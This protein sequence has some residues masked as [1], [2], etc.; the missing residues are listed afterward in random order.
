VEADATASRLRPEV[1][2]SAGCSLVLCSSKWCNMEVTGHAVDQFDV[3]SASTVFWDT[4]PVLLQRSDR[5][6]V[7]DVLSVRLLVGHTRH[8]LNMKVLRMHIFSDSDLLVLH[9]LEVSE[10]DF[11]TLKAE[12]GILVDFAN[13]SGK[14]IDLLRRCIASKDEDVPRFRA[15]LVMSAGESVFKMVE[16]NDFKQLPH[17]SL[18]FRPGTDMAIKSFL[19]FRLTEVQQE[20]STLQKDLAANRGELDTARR[21]LAEQQEL[22]KQMEAT[23]TKLQLETQANA[24]DAASAALAERMR[25]REELVSGLE[26]CAA[27]RC[28]GCR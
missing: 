2:R 5:E 10:E 23:H 14:I 6:D 1:A 16:T 8:S 4:V 7:V 25:E 3:S 12:Q 22:A 20:C 11:Q 13:F 18:C 26:R 9:T 19:A 15:V 27:C 24:R 28:C 21:C 17:I